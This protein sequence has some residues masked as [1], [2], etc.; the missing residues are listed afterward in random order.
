MHSLIED[1]LM[2]G[3][4]LVVSVKCMSQLA[5]IVEAIFKGVVIL[6]GGTIN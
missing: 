4:V 1:A 2:Y 5:H 6:N 3:S